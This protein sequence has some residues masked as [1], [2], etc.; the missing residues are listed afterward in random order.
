MMMI[1][2]LF[3][4]SFS[5]KLASSLQLPI[6]SEEALFMLVSP[7]FLWFFNP[8]IFLTTSGFLC[9]LGFNACKLQRVHMHDGYL[10]QALFFIIVF[11]S[12]FGGLI[13]ENFKVFTCMMGY[14]WQQA[15][16]L[17]IV[18]PSFSWV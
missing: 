3:C 1:I 9:F 8:S 10:W 15:L 2:M 5:A 17:I 14:L 12:S 4:T 11:P 6:G 16:L 18:F 13:H 7:V